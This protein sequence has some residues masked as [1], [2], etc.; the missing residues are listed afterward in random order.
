MTPTVD[1][2]VSWPLKSLAFGQTV[3]G[4]VAVAGEL[5]LYTFE[6]GPD[7]PVFFDVKEFLGPTTVGLQLSDRSGAL[8]VDT[9]LGCGDPGELVLERGGAYTIRVGD[10]GDDS[11]GTYSFQLTSQ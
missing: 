6:M 9:C 7:Q 8:L 11:T 5:D 4:E 10:S 1:L 3:E 2:V